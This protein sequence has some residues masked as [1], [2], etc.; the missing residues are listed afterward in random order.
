[1]EENHREASFQSNIL[2][3]RAARGINPDVFTGFRTEAPLLCGILQR[4]H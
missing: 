2:M 4:V 3:Q 1:M